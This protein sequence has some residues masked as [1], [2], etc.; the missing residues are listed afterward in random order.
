MEL[1]DLLQLY[2]KCPQ[3][4]AVV[5]ALGDKSV[6]S[7]YLSGLECGAL[8]VVVG[9]LAGVYRSGTIVLVLP[10]DDSAGYAYND[11]VHLTGEETALFFPSSYKRAAKYAQRDAG[12]EV[13]RTEV[14]SRLTGGRDGDGS[15]SRPTVVVTYPAALAELT[16][17]KDDIS[18]RLIRVETGQQLGITGFEHQLCALGFTRVDYVYEPG[19]VAVRGGIVDVYSYSSPL[20]FRIDFFGNEVDSIRTFELDTQLSKERKREVRILPS[21][22]PSDGERMPFTSFLSA[23]SLFIAGDLSFVRDKIRSIYEEGFTRQAITDKLAGADESEQDE[24]RRQMS[25]EMMFCSPSD[26]VSDVARLRRIT[27]GHHS[28]DAPQ[29]VV[30]FNISPQP[31]FHKNFP[32][33]KTT[34]ADYQKRGYK[35]YILADSDKQHRRLNEIITTQDDTDARSAPVNMPVAVRGILHEGFVDNNLRCCFF[36]D[37]QIFDRFHK[38]SLKSDKV[39]AGKMSLTMKELMEMVPGD[40]LVHID[41]G[42]GRFGGLVRKPTGKGYKEEIRLIYQRGD[43]V[44]VSI[45][46]LYK[47]S[48]YR[49]GDSGEPP[50]LSTL[51]T[52]AW[53]RL[54]ENTKRRIKDVA[55]DLI[56]LYAKRRHEKGFAFSP[57]S[58]LQHELE[59]S[60]LYEDTPDQLRTTQEV[61]TDME[62]DRPMDRLICGDV[63][64]GKTEVAVRAAFKACL[65]GKQVAV[66]VPTTVLAFQHYQTFKAR[67]SGFPVTVEYLSR[68]RSVKRAKEIL[69]DLEAGRVDI[70]IGTHKLIN[71]AVKWRDLGLL[72]IDEEQKFGVSVKEKLRT[73]KTNI[74]TITMS[75]TPI[76]R[77]LQFSLM[78]ARDMSIMRTPP[79]NR[80][81]IATTVTTFDKQLIADAINFEMSSNGQIFFVNNRVNNLPEIAAMIKRAVPDCRVAIGHG[82]MNS[83]ELE[84]ILIGFINYDYDLLL[85]TTIVENGVDIPNANTIIIN[86]AQRFGLSDLHQMRGRV[87]RSNRKAFCY[88]LAPPLSSLPAEACRRLNAVET[89]AGLGAGFAL[90]MQDLD[91]RGAGNL[92]GTEQSGFIED[93]GYETYQKILT[94]AV[95]ELKDQEFKDLY[96]EEVKENE[97][98]GG[99]HNFTDDCTIESDLEMYFPDQYVPGSSERVLLYRE[100]D[101]IQSDEELAAYR[102]RLVDRFGPVPHEG[103]ELMNVVLLR[104]YGRRLG[105]EKIILRSG[106][107]NMQFVSSPDSAFYRSRTFGGVLDFVARNARRCRFK[108]ING[109]RLMHVENVNSVGEAVA[110]L[111]S[112][113]PK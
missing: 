90:S 112:I 73:L 96:S 1:K 93:L 62:S 12:N 100:L 87:G 55:R 31:L 17:K 88:L 91:I 25:R 92:L 5:R 99:E 21:L 113:T 27:F 60:F 36:T 10:D 56:K 50:R 64:F 54:K 20:P 30:E 79:P 65:D 108:E 46:S 82:Q 2:A 80:Y 85:S 33:L 49:S 76:P 77:T 22:A 45:H 101:N 15:T 41:F 104:R 29:A 89:F 16:A 35:T 103:E 71:K 44:D 68:G 42:I 95:T 102:S 98:R 105:C 39:R 18:S 24:I 6:R 26:F 14:L 84:R 107:L 8:P 94:Q 83:E 69:A 51:G 75:A 28:P 47:I 81:P 13:L 53:E 67:L 40:Y 110:L 9:A 34:L 74:D 70:L 52:G 23:D 48:K 97:Q 61:K 109:R 63:G 86:D 7:L 58:Y 37:H 32:L 111:R 57:D 59:A 106:L 72:I 11:L 4:R 3:V 43:I 38:Y 19:Q 66:L 78:G